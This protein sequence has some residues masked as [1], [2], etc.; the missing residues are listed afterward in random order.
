MSRPRKHARRETVGTSTAATSGGNYTVHMSENSI[1]DLLNPEAVTKIVGTLAPAGPRIAPDKMRQAVESI[2]AAAEVSVD[3]VHRITGLEAAHNLRDSQVLVTDR[4]TWAKA[5]A[6]AFSVMLEPVL[7]APLEKI[8]Q[9]N[10]AALSIT[11][12]GIATEVGS[13]LAYLSTR[14]LGQYEPYAALAGYGAAGGRLMLVA[15]NILAVEKELNVEPEDFRLWVCLH[16]QTHRVQFAAAPWLRD[17]FLNKIAQ[18][19]DSVST[20]LS[21]KDALVASKG[22]RTDEADNEPQIGEQLAALA[23]TPARAKQIASEITAVM[24]LLE[25]HAN[26]IM[27]AVD[28]EIVPTVKTIRRRFNRRSET[29]KLVTRLISRL[30]GLHRKA[31]QYRDGQKFVQHIVDAVGMERF[32]T[33][34]ERPENLPT[35]REIHNPDA[36]MKRVLDEGSEVTSAVKYGEITE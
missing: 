6:Q 5:N 10:P 27:D 32:N 7:R 8:R 14:V 3:H 1:Q 31:A 35:E 11:G 9:K 18:L 17:Y 25:G 21:I 12:Y 29:Q 22:A 23:K 30:L 13:I 33:V 34:W 36:W 4:S 19:G 26:V 15:P 20:G 2:R 24:S 28:A 16:E